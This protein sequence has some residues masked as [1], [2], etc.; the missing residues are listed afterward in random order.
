ML[1]I[2]AMVLALPCELGGLL[3]V[4]YTASDPLN[5]MQDDSHFYCQYVE[6]QMPFKAI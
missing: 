1:Q 6:N 4:K 5:W 2:K 3:H